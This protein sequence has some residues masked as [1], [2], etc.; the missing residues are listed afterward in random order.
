MESKELMIGDKILNSNGEIV[1]IYGITQEGYTYENQEGDMC[2]GMCKISKPIELC[3]EFLEKN[4]FEYGKKGRE[5]ALSDDYYD[6]IVA[7]WSDSIWTIRYECT[8]MVAPHHQTTCS[9][10]HEFQHFLKECGLSELA[11]NL[12]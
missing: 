3:G 12:K 5:W 6:I 1:T 2:Y 9:Y 7:E 10:V 11:E 8:E 4:G